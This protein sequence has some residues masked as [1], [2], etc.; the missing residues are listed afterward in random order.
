MDQLTPQS[1]MEDV[2]E[3]LALLSDIDT[4]EKQEE[5]GQVYSQS[6]V[7]KRSQQWLK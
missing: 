1:T 7:E 6:E 3:Q 2:Y 4:S 5:N